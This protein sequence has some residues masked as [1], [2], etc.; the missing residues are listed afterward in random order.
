MKL[1]A[2]V[3]ADIR[4]TQKKDATHAYSRNSLFAL[5]I[6]LFSVDACVCHRKYIADTAATCGSQTDNICFNRFQMM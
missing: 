1:S 5:R 4:N 3:F 6:S 2:S